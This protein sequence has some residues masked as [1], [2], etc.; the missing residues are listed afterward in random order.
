MTLPE[1]ITKPGQVN[2]IMGNDQN[3]VS[4][5]LGTDEDGKLIS[6]KNYGIGEPA[7]TAR[8][9]GSA[10]WCRTGISPLDQKSTTGWLAN[11]YGGIQSAWDDYARIEIPIDEKPISWLTSAQWTYYLTEA[12][13]MGINM[14]IWVHDPNDLAKRAEITQQADI[15]T[16]AKAA[17]WNRHIL[18]PATDQFYYYGEGT[19]GTGLTEG[20]P[21]YY[22]LDDFQADKVFG[23]WSIYKITFDYGWHTGD[24]EF[25]DGWVADIKLNGHLVPLKPDSGGSGRIGRRFAT[26][27]SAIATALTPKTPFQLLSVE[28]H[29]DAA[30]TQETFTVTK[31]GGKAA[32]VYDTLLFSKAMSGLTDVVKYFND[33]KFAQED[34]IDC[35]WTNTDTRTYGIT[36]TYKIIEDGEAG[37]SGQILNGEEIGITK[38]DQTTPG[39]TNLVAVSAVKTIQTELLAITAIA[40]GAQQKSST[41][42]LTGIKKATVLIDHGR[43]ATTAFVGAGTEYRV[44]VSQKAAGNDTWRSI[45]SVVCGIA[46]ATEITADGD[47]AAAQTLI[48][49]GANTPA[50]ND[51]LFWENATLANSEWMKVVA[52]D[53]GVT[54]TILDGL[55]NAQA[56]ANK[57][58]NKAEQFT[59]LLDVEAYTRMRV[60]VNNNNGSTNAAIKS[61]IACITEV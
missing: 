30:A 31:D 15:A 33:M 14:V 20:P 61:R 23:K 11:L 43:T 44:E 38:I 27:A 53:A 18:V 55:T 37:G 26:G 32:T 57:I 54:F 29:L 56:A 40:A 36:V 50:V 42:A 58:Y 41:L 51:I 52:I 6:G 46:T 21:N 45:A 60:V 24:N 47:E 19:T 28:V 59:L 3:A 17:G 4:R 1:P 13:A 8:N 34:E 35:A 2:L 9:N 10:T 16:L 39:T 25:K 48:E 49:I 7:L 5:V 22:G 12:E